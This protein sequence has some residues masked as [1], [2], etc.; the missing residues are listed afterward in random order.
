MD[1]LLLGL[2]TFAVVCASPGPAV[3]AVVSTAMARG[4]RAAMVLTAGLSLAL[5]AW[6]LLAAAGF[7]AVL[8]A[9]PSALLAFKVAGGAYLLWLAWGA[10]RAA[11]QPG[12]APAAGPSGFRAGLILNLSN[13]KSV[14]AW[15]ATIAVGT[16]PDMPALAW[17]LVPAA[18]AVTVA[19]YALYAAAFSRPLLRRAYGTAR[20]WIDG[21]TSALFALAGL[22]LLR[23]AALQAVRRS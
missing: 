9:A 15:T 23:D 5:G 7:G 12:A 2:A 18:M 6:G 8:A 19:I 3:V 13:P 20:R 21:A 1:T 14:F 16:P 10:G 17:V 4:F 22:A 11:A